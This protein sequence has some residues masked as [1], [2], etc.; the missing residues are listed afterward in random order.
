MPASNLVALL[1]DPKILILDEATSSLDTESEA[2]V[3]EALTRLMR[4]RT[5]LIIA[6]RLSTVQ[7]ADKILALQNGKIVEAGRHEELLEKGGLYA[8]L[9]RSQFTAHRDT[10]FRPFD[11]PDADEEVATAGTAAHPGATR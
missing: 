6:H 7:H 2:L 4:G 9:V 8:R 3:Q 1:K 5:C 11:D 10:S